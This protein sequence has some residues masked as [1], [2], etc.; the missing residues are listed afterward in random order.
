MPVSTGVSSRVSIGGNAFCFASFEDSSTQ[1][2]VVNPSAIC[3]SRDPIVQRVATGRKLVQFQLTHD[4]TRPILDQLLALAGTTRTGAGTQASPWLYTANES[5][6]T[7]EICVDK[8]GAKH[9]YTSCRLQ[10]LVLRG[11]VGTMPIQ[12]ES[13]WI[14][15]DEI[16]DAAFSFVDGT[17]DNLIAFPGAELTVGGVAA[18]HDRY[19][20]V[21]DNR[22]VPSWNASETV[23]DVGPGPRQVLL[24]F[25]CPY[26]AANKDHYWLNRA[27][28]PRALSHRIT[29]GND[30]L[31]FSMGYGVLVPQSPSVPGATEEI[32]INETWEAY[33]SGNDPAFTFSL[34]GT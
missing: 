30:S 5:V 7:T 1:E 29:N 2:R 34:Y 21:I 6:S 24:A 13:T 25:A 11:Q 19:A 18:A 27:V 31:T 22:L 32:R 14:A 20:I 26:I 12:A 33:R 9:K 10:R 3:G 16:E 4:A 17:V 8:V 15:T 28:T 23:T